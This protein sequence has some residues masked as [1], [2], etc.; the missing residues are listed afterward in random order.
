MMEA[1]SRHLFYP[2][3]DKKDGSKRLPEW[4][5]LE[6]Q[7]WWPQEKIRELQWERVMETVRYAATHSP[8]YRALFNTLGL[9]ATDII[10]AEQFR[11]LP[12]TTKQDLRNQ[13]DD[14]I[15]DEFAKEDLVCAKTGGSTG[16]SLKLY[17]D[18]ACQE[19]RNA[20][21]WLADRWAGWDL[22]VKKASVWG[23][24][25]VPRTIKQKLRHHLLDRT[26]YLDTMDL[27]DQ[28]MAEFV[29]RW[30]KEKPGLVFGHAH[31]IFI[32]AKYLL[33]QDVR[34]LQ[35]KGI[36]A[37]S[38]M[39]LQ[40]ERSV[41]EQAFS[42]AV[43]NRYGCEEVGLIACQCEQHQGM[44]L[45][46]PHVYV[47]FLDAN[48][49]PVAPG[50][51][52]K[53]VVTDLN[54]RGMPLIRY[55]VEDV[56]VY[57]EEPCGCGRGFPILERLE[58]RVAD[59]L[60]LPDG[61][62]VAGISLVER[63]LTKVPGIEQMQLVQD[64]LDH[65]IINRVKGREFDKETDEGL[66]NA[67]REVFDERVALTIKDVAAIPQESSGKYRFSICMV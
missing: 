36:V 32:F 25:P 60:K 7:Q 52:G 30:R 17:F 19:R 47:E 62:Q 53:I 45:N 26:I 57:S 10:S 48:D 9:E 6:A 21:Q 61:G 35:P 8:Y 18:E 23:N 42:C 20:A 41:I 14:F 54:N 67:M 49:Q 43:T 15:S 33:E 5:Q 29:E 63:T 24:P 1:L 31:S 56:G 66:I 34:D 37:T 59:F 44:H 58:G 28:S 38:M 65:V 11:R 4:R 12:V 13:L 22:G 64:A 27:N 2:L 3:W 40:S 46:L 50:E 16:V 51:P 55:R 39:L